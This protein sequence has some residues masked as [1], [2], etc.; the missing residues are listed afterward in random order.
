MPIRHRTHGVGERLRALATALA[1]GAL[2][3]GAL[4]ACSTDRLLDVESPT[5]VPADGLEDPSN[6]LLLVNG[7]AS[8]FDCAFQTYVVVGGLIGEELDD[9]TQTAARWPYDR[10]DV[11]PNQSF[12]ATNSCEGLGVYTPLQTARVS[13][14]N[15]KRLL[16]RW[17]DAQVA[18]RTALLARAA[19]YEGWSQ[20]LL[21]EGFCTTVFSTFEGT[22]FNFG[23][24]TPRQQ[25]LQTAETTF[26]EAITAAQAVGGATGDSL[27]YLALVGRA[28]ARL[29]LGNLAGARTDAAQVPASFVFNSTASAV[30]G[31]RTN[32]VY[33]ESN[34]LGVSSSVGATYRAMNDPRIPYV[35]LNRPNALGVAAVGQ[36]KYA[37]AASPI[38]LATGAEAQLIVAEA[39]IASNPAS[40]VAIVDGFRAAGNQGAYTGPTDAASLKAQVID[41]RR[42]ALFLTGTHLGDLIRYNLAPQ[43]ATGAKYPAGGEYGNQLCMP[44]PDA[45]KQNNPMFRS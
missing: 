44:L 14:N 5:R 8:D 20:L 13:A 40:T 41:Q 33:S 3:A 15:V 24:E 17:T 10:R 29:D 11:Q 25:A 27:R 21:A 28:R 9:Y 6:A 42:R 4:A 30:S 39:D 34:T 36:L 32:R 31:R 43:P 38:P 1:L 35:N 12:Y 16:G 22:Q 23:A 26:G 18:G 45:E 7:A 19:A 2:A 37:T